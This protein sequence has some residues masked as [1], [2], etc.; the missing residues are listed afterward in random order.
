LDRSIPVTRLSSSQ[1]QLAY[2]IAQQA[3]HIGVVLD[4]EHQFGLVVVLNRHVFISFPWTH[5]KNHPA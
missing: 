1:S 3:S 4:H 5:R 2:D